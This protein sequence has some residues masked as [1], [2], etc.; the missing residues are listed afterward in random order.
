MFLSTSQTTINLPFSFSHYYYLRIYIWVNLTFQAMMPFHSVVLIWSKNDR[1]FRSPDS[2]DPNL[3]RET[4]ATSNTATARSEFH[5]RT[6]LE[7]Y[8]RFSKLNL[9]VFLPP[10]A[11]PPSAIIMG[12]APLLESQLKMLFKEEA[13]IRPCI[14]S[15]FSRFSTYISRHRKW[16]FENMSYFVQYVRPRFYRIGQPREI[17]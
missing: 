11:R 1:E 10:P 5:E 3:R 2:I 7:F 16:P 4:K 6:L 9:L 14:F 17:R 8:F 12:I 13:E 15:G